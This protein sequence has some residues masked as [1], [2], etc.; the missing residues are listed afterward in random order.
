M[1]TLR[2]CIVLLALAVGL[3]AHGQDSCSFER[4]ITTIDSIATAKGIELGQVNI[5]FIT[6]TFDKTDTD[7][8]SLTKK[9]KFHFEGQFLVIDDKY[10]NIN[11]LIYFR[12]KGRVLEFFFQGY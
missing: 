9:R 12:V 2:N 5:L 7:P 8:K 10:F 1:G 3:N 4:M 11:K 6:N